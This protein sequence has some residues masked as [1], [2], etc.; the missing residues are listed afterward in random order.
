MLNKIVLFI[1]SSLLKNSTQ[2]VILFFTMTFLLSCQKKVEYKKVDD[3]KS[4]FLSG[5]VI[6]DSHFL[7]DEK[8][9]ECHQQ[10][11]K[12]WQGSHHDKAMQIADRRLV[13]LISGSTLSL[14]SQQL[15]VL[16]P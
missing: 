9:K 12:A 15:L 6:P 13:P 16:W 4:V 7:G 1:K 5:K 3:K 14:I 10:E 2:I 8:C 11:F